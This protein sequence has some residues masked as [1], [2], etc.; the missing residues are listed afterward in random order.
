MFYMLRRI[1]FQFRWYFV[2]TTGENDDLHRSLHFVAFLMS[3][4]LFSSTIDGSMRMKT[5]SE[6]TS[7]LSPEVFPYRA[8]IKEGPV[9]LSTVSVLSVLTSWRISDFFFK[10]AF[11]SKALCQIK[12]GVNPKLIQIKSR[13][14]QSKCRTRKRPNTMKTES[15]H[16]GHKGIPKLIAKL[17]LS[18]SRSNSEKKN[19]R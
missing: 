12:S 9:Q 15:N 16:K 8:F 19:P 7:P 17:I 11:R 4:I 10:L 13:Q 14:V 3:K 6:S 1:V 2:F 18:K 5:S